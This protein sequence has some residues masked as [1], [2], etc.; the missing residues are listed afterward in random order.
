M[1]TV[2]FGVLIG[3]A[4]L[5]SPFPKIAAKES[6]MLAL[7]ILSLTAAILAGFNH[8]KTFPTSRPDSTTI[9]SN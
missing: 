3:L 2:F 8:V 4:V 6:V 1:L 9:N 5:L 7:A